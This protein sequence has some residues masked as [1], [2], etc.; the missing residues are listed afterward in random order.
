MRA[1]VYQVRYINRQ[2]ELFESFAQGVAASL[3]QGW[4]RFKLAGNGEPTLW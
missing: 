3:M 2:V 4:E 1:N